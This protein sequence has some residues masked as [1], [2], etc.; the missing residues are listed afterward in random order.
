MTM[1]PMRAYRQVVKKYSGIKTL[2]DEAMRHFLDVVLPT[3]P[4]R[5]QQMFVDEILFLTTG[6]PPTYADLEPTTSVRGARTPR[7]KSIRSR[8]NGQATQEAFEIQRRAVEVFGTEAKA[9][10]WL[11][12]PN[13]TGKNKSPLTMLGTK[14]GNARVV[15]ILNRVSGR[16]RGS[17]SPKARSGGKKRR[18]LSQ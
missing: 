5:T 2:T 18:R 13:K 10:A 1:G 11:T 8:G 12:R 17:Q 3:L 4:H 16:L 6:L 7:S 9:R 15:A 14:A